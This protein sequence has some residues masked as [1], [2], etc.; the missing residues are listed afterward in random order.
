MKE[1]EWAK[2]VAVEIHRHLKGIPARLLRYGDRFDFM[3]VW[4]CYKPKNE[5]WS[6]LV[7]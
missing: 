6:V 2:T 3:F 5:E 1:Q 7:K 4:E